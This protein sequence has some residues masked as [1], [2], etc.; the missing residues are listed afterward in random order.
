MIVSSFQISDELQMV[1]IDPERA[2][3]AVEIRD[4]RIWL[5]VQPPNSLKSKRG[6]TR[7]KLERFSTALSRSK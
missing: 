1:L 6:S 3:Q 5:D 2:A 7:L 4:V